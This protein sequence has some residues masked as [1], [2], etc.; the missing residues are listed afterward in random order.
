VPSSIDVFVSYAHEDLARVRPLVEALKEHGLS[1]WFDE[2][3]IQPHDGITR[4]V[5]EGLGRSKVLVAYYSGVY[6]TRRACQW[7][8]T[9]AF[10]AA[11]ALGEDPRRRVLVINPER[12][13]G[14]ELRADH[15]QPVQ[16]RDALFCIDARHDDE[17][18]W[19]MTE[20]TRIAEIVDAH[21]R[22]L[23]EARRTMPRQVGR[24]LVDMLGFVGR[25]DDLWKVH[26]ALSEGDAVQ[27]TGSAGGEVAQITGLGGIGKSLLAEEYALRFADAYPGGVFWLRA[28]GVREEKA[29]SSEDSGPVREGNA[30]LHE[31]RHKELLNAEHQ[32]ARHAQVHR[33]A[34]DLG[35]SAEDRTSEEIRSDIGRTIAQAGPC[36]WI[37]D[38]LPEGLE[39][40][41]VRAWLAPHPNAKTLITTRSRGYELG[42]RIGLGGLSAEDGY[43]LLTA[44][45]T[46]G[47]DPDEEIAGHELVADLGGHPLALT[48]AGHSLG[49]E[50]GLRTFAEYRLAMAERV[51][52][53]LKL[54]EE[55]EPQLSNRRGSSI[56]ATL[57]D[58]IERLDEPGRDLLRVMSML[59]PA[60]F[61][62][63]MLADVFAETDGLSAADARRRVA[64]AVA[65]TDAASLTE[66]A[67]PDG[68]TFSVHALVA[69]TVAFEDESPGRVRQL[70]LAAPLA[71]FNHVHSLLEATSRVRISDVYSDKVWADFIAHSRE[72]SY[73]AY[74][75]SDTGFSGAVIPLLDLV[76]TYDWNS[77]EYRSAAATWQVVVGLLEAAGEGQDKNALRV[78]DY[79][80]DTL[81]TLGETDRAR[82]LAQEVVEARERLLPPDDPETLTAMHTLAVA[83]D[84]SEASDMLKHL[85]ETHAR[86]HGEHDRETLK[87]MADLALQQIDE[88]PTA[89][90][91]EL[92]RIL[93]IQ[94]QSWGDDDFDTIK[95][96]HNLAAVLLAQGERSRAGELFDRVLAERVLLRGPD[97]EET[98]NTMYY[99]GQLLGPEDPDAART[100]LER[101]VAGR[102]HMYGPQ[103]EKTAHAVEALARLSSGSTEEMV[104]TVI[105]GVTI[106]HPADV[107]LPPLGP[108]S[109]QQTAAKARSGTPS[110]THKKIGRN[111]PC[112]CGSGKKYKRCHGERS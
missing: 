67:D 34:V 97:H 15:V 85:A 101:V 48:L 79:L 75:E 36:L 66:P 39:D 99:V 10:L 109:Q 80:A 22:T 42:R 74:S 5:R 61:S 81:T 17:A 44:R 96:R 6:P 30:Q 76:A 7:E 27:I 100:M 55:L 19:A 57:L 98:L 40:Q 90:G 9:A 3:A 72:L 92:Q 8:L 94:E 23:G 84:K 52:D 69:R 4:L 54:A 111:D 1:V 65:Q 107:V 37:V 11:E 46:P 28:S 21:R 53:E 104:T 106:A 70:R 35:L 24:R 88:D 95:T 89:A 83:S 87:A 64:L 56:A 102:E 91:K 86:E 50:A 71:L 20:A 14:G 82:E 29:A 33:I 31:V 77:R 49:V 18:G 78:K 112:H 47:E 93:E 73:N 108:A 16:L 63:R 103:A 45:R 26:S 43:A 51:E 58:S 62:K 32:P 41:E 12:G 60:P 25:L 13:E 68:E 38:D 105:D 110:R 2:S 59:A